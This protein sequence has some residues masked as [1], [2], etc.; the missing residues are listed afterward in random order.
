MRLLSP[1]PLGSQEDGGENRLKE[2]TT[3]FCIPARVWTLGMKA[4]EEKYVWTGSDINEIER[5]GRS[6]RQH[7]EAAVS[8][9]M[10]ANKWA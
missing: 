9:G 8:Q 10:L 6:G 7:R 4:K 2:E 3:A 5:F 1:V